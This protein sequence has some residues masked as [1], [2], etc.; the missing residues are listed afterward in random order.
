ML[1]NKNVDLDRH[2]PS[3]QCGD[4]SVKI[5][6]VQFSRGDRRSPPN[7]LRRLLTRKPQIGRSP[8]IER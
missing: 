6:T 1:F 4:R 7:F 3:S 2:P 5:L 8:K